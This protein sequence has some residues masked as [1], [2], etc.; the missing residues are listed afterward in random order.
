MPDQHWLR[1]S[2]ARVPA[3][4]WELRRTGTARRP[5]PSFL[6]AASRSAAGRHAPGV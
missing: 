2:R 1:A 4:R 3:H 6:W 5:P